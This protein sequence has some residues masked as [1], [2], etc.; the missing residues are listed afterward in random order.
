MIQLNHVVK[1]FHTDHEIHAVKD[2]S[3][4]IADGEI[5]GVIGFS[6]AGKSTLVRC[7][8]LLERPD[9][10]EVLVDNQDLMLLPQPQLRA[11]RKKIG[12]IFQHF[13]LFRSRTVGSNIAFPLKYSGMSQEA[14]EE[15]V[16]ELLKLVDLED[17]ALSYPS[18]LS[19]G[20]KQRVGIARALASNP[21][22]LLCDEATSALDP[23]T[24]GS[25]LSLLKELNK[26]LGI[27]IIIITHEMLVIKSICGRAAVMDQGAVIEEGSI[28][29]LFSNPRQQI[30]RDFIATTSH[31]NKI[32]DL[33]A[34]DSPVVRLA[35]GQILAHFSYQGRNT[36]D[37]LISTASIQFNV[38]LNIIFGDLDIIQETPMGG[39]II[40]LEGNPEA[41][42]QTMAWFAE[43]GVRVEVIKRG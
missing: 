6:G 15:R 25:I 16:K 38:K 22:I 20:Q 11:A 13:N 32:F 12:M 1:T 2:V 5:F 17:K 36:V 39:L 41:V 14:I 26:K 18:Q 34:E 4:S 19:G 40:I 23:Q 37:A 33:L 31:L 3:L 7:I 21:S 29:D 10:G 42:S 24:T 28:F 9:A 27:T 8:N 30:T 43:K 35:P